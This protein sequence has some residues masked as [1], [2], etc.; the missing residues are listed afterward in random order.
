[1]LALISQNIAEVSSLARLILRAIDKNMQEK[2][3][4]NME[5]EEVYSSAD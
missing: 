4:N 1:M 5:K 3:A 2:L